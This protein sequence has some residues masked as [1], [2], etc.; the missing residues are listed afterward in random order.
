MIGSLLFSK[1]EL[2]FNKTEFNFLIFKSPKS[3]EIHFSCPNS[4]N[5][6]WSEI[7]MG[8]YISCINQF[9]LK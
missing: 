6:M 9:Q 8:F 1:L 2:K 5:S 3:D 7:D 4:I